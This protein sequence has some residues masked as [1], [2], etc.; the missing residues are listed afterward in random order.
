MISACFISK[1]E[2]IRYVQYVPAF[3]FIEFNIYDLNL[4]FALMMPEHK[5]LISEMLRDDRKRL[6]FETLV[7]VEV[8]E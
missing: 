1:Q 6:R 5:K 8:I 4:M 2:H 7:G 3:D